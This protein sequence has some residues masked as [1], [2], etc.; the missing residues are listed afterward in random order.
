MVVEAQTYWTRETGNRLSDLRLVRPA[1]FG[2]IAREKLSDWWR[3]VR[4]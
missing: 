4:R 1:T 3:L 2:E